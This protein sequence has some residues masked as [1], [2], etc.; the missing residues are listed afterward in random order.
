MHTTFTI[1]SCSSRECPCLRKQCIRTFSE[2]I[3][4]CQFDEEALCSCLWLHSRALFNTKE[5]EVE[6]QRYL[7]AV[8]QGDSDAIRS[9]ALCFGVYPC[10]VQLLDGVFGCLPSFLL[11]VEERSVEYLKEITQLFKK[12]THS[13]SWDRCDSL[14]SPHLACFLNPS[15][16]CALS[17]RVLLSGFSSADY[18]LLHRLRIFSIVRKCMSSMTACL[19]YLHT[20]DAVNIAT[21]AGLA[22]LEVDYYQTQAIR[23]T[24]CFEISASSSV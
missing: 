20:M 6:R 4:L 14:S 9:D 5:N 13:F 2:T 18:H 17:L 21:L 16:I 12:L 10:S 15:Q 11:S 1:F 22:P 23:I 7:A 24:E 3:K 19:E 8:E